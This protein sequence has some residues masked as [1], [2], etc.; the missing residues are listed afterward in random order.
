LPDRVAQYHAADYRNPAQ[1][2]DGG[3]LVV[4]SAQSGCQ[5]TEELLGS[6]RHVVLATSAVGRVPTPYRGRHIVE[7]AFDTGWFDERPQDLPDPAMMQAPIPLFAPGCHA[8]ACRR[9]LGPARP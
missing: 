4:G 2:P 1:L 6:G 8:L 3:V 5:I 7:W 9:W